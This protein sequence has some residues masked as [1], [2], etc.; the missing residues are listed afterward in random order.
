MSNPRARHTEIPA[1]TTTAEVAANT[2][3]GTH[4]DA[5]QRAVVSEGMDGQRPEAGVELGLGPAVLL[6]PEQAAG[7]L[8]VPGSW[9]RERAA[10]GMVPCRRLGKYLRFTRTDL[11]AIA[12]VA[13][14]PA[15]T[16]APSPPTGSGST[17]SRP[18]GTTPTATARGS[19]SRAVGDAAEQDRPGPGGRGRTGSGRGAQRGPWAGCG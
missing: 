15:T 14:R 18:A 16:T 8:S 11:D 4:I 2:A 13:A 12:A 6:T 3:R 17:R 7:L 1:D 9:L 5:G 10:A 19:R